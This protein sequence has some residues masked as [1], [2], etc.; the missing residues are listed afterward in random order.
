MY[1]LRKSTYQVFVLAILFL[2]SNAI[3]QDTSIIRKYNDAAKRCLDEGMDSVEYYNKLSLTTSAKYRIPNFDGKYIQTYLYI[4]KKKYSDALPNIK[5]LIYLANEANNIKQQGKANYLYA[6]WYEEQ[7]DVINSLVYAERALKLREKTN[8]TSQILS[9]V[10]Q[11][12]RIYKKNNKLTDGLACYLRAARLAEQIKDS[13]HIYSAYINLGTL[14][15]KTEDNKKALQFY[16]KALEINKRDNDTNGYAI[17]YLKLSSAWSAEKNLDSSYYYINKCVELQRIQNNDA[18]LVSSLAKLAGVLAEKG[19]YVGAIKNFD[20]VMVIAEK[21]NDALAL[22]WALTGKAKTLYK[23]KK[24][25]EALLLAERGIKEDKDKNDFGFISLTHKLISDISFA[26]GDFKKA[27]ENQVLYK[28]ALD[29]LLARNDVKKQTELKLSYEFDKIQEKQKEE[30]LAKE[31]ENNLRLEAAKK[32]RYFL[33]AFLIL[34]MIIVVIA[35]RSYI[36]K[37]KSSLL[38]EKKNLQLDSQKQLLEVKNKEISD[39]INYAKHIQTTCL[40]DSKKLNDCFDDFYLLFKPRD[41]VSG[42]FFWTEQIEDTVLLGVAD[43]TGH[44]VPGAIM[45]VIGSILLNEIFVVKKIYSPEKVLQELNRVVKLTLKQEE[46]SNAQDGMDIAFCAWN[47]KTNVLNYS[48]ANRSLIIITAQGELKEYKP[49]KQPIGGSTKIDQEYELQTISLSEGDRI[50]IT[51]DGFADQ[52]GGSQLKKINTK[53]LKEKLL[54]ISKLSSQNQ[55][56]ELDLYFE[57]WKGSLEQTDD[58]LVFSFKA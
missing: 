5:R 25:N 48:G 24:Y 17:C 23:L 9:S 13:S 36:T 56:E 38:L 20:E 21:R 15:Q 28:I 30:S 57:E 4:K 26:K 2:S 11:L 42:D 44:G 7:N 12:G 27:Y 37:R 16:N 46:Q 53:K 3:S 19:D 45:S 52:F 18:G 34:A 40:P 10:S 47:K 39:S 58:V 1:F 50:V 14:Y 29:T 55:K 51:T 31:V 35:V 43:C 54:S 49:T 41:V 33:I 6:L 32:Q 22:C 8:D